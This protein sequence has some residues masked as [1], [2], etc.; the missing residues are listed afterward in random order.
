MCTLPKIAEKL[1]LGPRLKVVQG[2]RCWYLRK[3]CRRACYDKQQICAICNRFH[4]RR[5]DSGQITTSKGVS[6]F[7]ALV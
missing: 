2:H 1:K 4:A 3:A 7:D 6:F 5:V